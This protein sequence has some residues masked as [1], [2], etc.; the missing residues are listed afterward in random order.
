MRCKCI[1]AVDDMYI[2]H[3]NQGKQPQERFNGMA[4]MEHDLSIAGC[5]MLEYT[6][7]NIGRWSPLRP[8]QQTEAWRK[9]YKLIEKS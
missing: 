9:A 3:S 5:W 7:S 6:V 2:M 4:S 1:E 8:T